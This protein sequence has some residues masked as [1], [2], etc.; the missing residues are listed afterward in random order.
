M[1]LLSENHQLLITT[2]RLVLQPPIASD[3]YVN[4]YVT[5]ID[6][7]IYQLKPWLPWAKHVPS[8][9]QAEWYI[10]TCSKNWIEKNNNDLG[11][12]IWIINQTTK[13]LI[14][15]MTIWN[16][17]WEIPKF[18]FGYW[19]RTSQT[20]KGYITE[21]VNALTRYSFIQM[22][23]NRIEIRCESGNTRAQYVPQRLN[24]TLDGILKKSTRVISSNELTDTFL[25]SRVDLD[26]LPDLKVSW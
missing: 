10:E 24:F 6:E 9:T 22:G 3:F 26:N 11:L 12:V 14:G 18:E 25:F 4:E 17:V 16:I 1:S 19:L 2:P 8:C 23:A 15:S 5:A 7:S 21:A 20:G 13:E